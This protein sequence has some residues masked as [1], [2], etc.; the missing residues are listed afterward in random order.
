MCFAGSAHAGDSEQR[1]SELTKI[2]ES[3]SYSQG[4]ITKPE[5]KNLPQ[6]NMEVEYGWR[7]SCKKDIFDGKKICYMH[8]Y[9]NDLM[10]NIIN[11]KL[12]IYVGKN[13]FPRTKSAIKIDNNQTIYGYEGVS[14]T[15]QKVVEQMKKG[16][17]AYTRYKEWPYEYNKDGEV[18]LTGFA[19]KY[20]EMVKQYQAL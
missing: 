9:G 15:P 6:L 19:E 4:N 18:D 7:V 12:G 5:G 10:V 13:H 11:G 1:I 17:T 3:G 14:Q 16:K 20:D 8:Q 2:L